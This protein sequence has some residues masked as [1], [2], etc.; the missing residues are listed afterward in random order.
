MVGTPQFIELVRRFNLHNRFDDVVRLAINQSANT[1]GIDAARMLL[2]TGQGQRF[3]P[4]LRNHGSAEQLEA[5]M[6]LGRSAD[7]RCCRC[8]SR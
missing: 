3:Q 4:L 5:V 8:W 1:A 6:V 2:D 7:N